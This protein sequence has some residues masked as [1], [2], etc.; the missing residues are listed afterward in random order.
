M[1]QTMEEYAHLRELAPGEARKRLIA[2]AREQGPTAL[3]AL[4]AAL[5]EPVLA[6]AALEALAEVPVQEAWD[7]LEQ[8]AQ[9][10]TA[11]LRKAAR[12]SQHRLRSRGFRPAPITPHQETAPTVEQARATSFDTTGNQFLRLVRSAALGMGHYA[13]FIVGPEGLVECNHV[14]INR[15]D[16]DDILAEED[17]DFGEELVKV[18]L[19]YVA[20]RA[21]AAAARNRAAGKALPRDWPEAARLLEDAPEDP[22]PAEL[23]AAAAQEAAVTPRD[24]AR[25]LRHPRMARWLLDTE[26]L[27]PYAEEWL[28]LVQYQPIRTEEGLPNLGAIQ[29]QGQLVGRIL[30]DLGDAATVQRLAEQLGEQARLFYAQGDHDLAGLALRCSAGLEQRPGPD[31]PFLRALVE[32][33]MNLAVRLVQEAIQEEAQGPWIQAGGTAG[34]LWVPRPAAPEEDEEEKPA[35]RLWLPGQP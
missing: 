1:E 7:L 15:A 17:A 32:V 22:L 19:A 24:G 23:A 20:R 16:L 21:R 35:P 6:E 28:H 11:G 26:R 27:A 10:E 3:A 30:A 9:A 18:G 29:S 31:N 8:A 2:L 25:L 12:R 13:N 14:L 33:S 34:P 5:E 4:R